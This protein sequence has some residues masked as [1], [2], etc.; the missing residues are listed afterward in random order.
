M[1]DI[2]PRISGTLS[3][4]QQQELR[5]YAD[6]LRII[7]KKEGGRRWKRSTLTESNALKMLPYIRE[8]YTSR[9]PIEIP[10]FPGAKLDTM[11]LKWMGALQ[12]FIEAPEVSQDLRNISAMVRSITRPKKDHASGTLIIGFT[13]PDA[14]NYMS[15]GQTGMPLAIPTTQEKFVE[16]PDEVEQRRRSSI[17]RQA[18]EIVSMARVEQGTQWKED[19]I[20]WV[21]SGEAGVP[22][23]R[24][25]LV[26]TNDDVEWIKSFAQN[27]ELMSEI[28]PNEIRLMKQE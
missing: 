20:E 1:S 25:N 23:I 22:F 3:E 7:T 13:V 12:W 16:T 10:C 2:L 8:L 14:A 19:L 27:A 24:K 17:D 5:T 26:L 6:S 18:A 28:K 9:K 15:V 11:Y 21:Q 4:Q